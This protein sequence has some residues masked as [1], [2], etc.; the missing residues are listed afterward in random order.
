MHP[1]LATHDI[2]VEIFNYLSISENTPTIS[3]AA[4]PCE[5]WAP[6]N[7]RIKLQRGPV[8]ESVHRDHVTIQ[9]QTLYSLALTCSAFSELALDH[10]WAAPAGGLYTVFG[11]LSGFKA[12][13]GDVYDWRDGKHKLNLEQFVTHSLVYRVFIPDWRRFLAMGGKNLR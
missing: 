12:I 13:R 6:R 2:L 10:L 4:R 8:Q 9:R 3:S 11:L 5:Y 1:A 7:R